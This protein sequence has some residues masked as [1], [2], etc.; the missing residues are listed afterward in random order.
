MS[1][2]TTAPRRNKATASFPE[3]LEPLF[4]PARYKCI[5]GGRGAGKSHAVATYLLSQAAKAPMR[6]LCGRE[7]QSSIRESVHRLLCD[8]IEALGL[9]KRF[10]ILENSI[11]GT[12]GSEFVFEGLR[13]NISR[14]RSLEGIDIAWVVTSNPAALCTPNANQEANTPGNPKTKI[15][16]GSP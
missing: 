15:T 2:S 8:K 6:I 5:Y 14:I 4:R 12:N 13:H 10:Q 1:S 16:V 11:R 7:F 3:A 9:G